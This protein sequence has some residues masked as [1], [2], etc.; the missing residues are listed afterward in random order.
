[1]HL[2]ITSQAQATIE[3]ASGWPTACI[4]IVSPGSRRPYGLAKI[5]KQLC[6]SF[7]DYER[8]HADAPKPSDVRAV[9]DFAQTLT[10]ADR[11]LVH[12]F[13]GVSRSSACAFVVLRVRGSTPEQ[14]HAELLRVQPKADP[15]TLVLH[16]FEGLS[17]TC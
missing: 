16:Y 2:K 12:C 3:L 11:L 1:M 6:L 15:N 5:Q 9:M 7:E 10:D 17:V 13:A 8:E 4:S 14:A